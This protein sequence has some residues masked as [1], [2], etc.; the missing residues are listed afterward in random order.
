MSAK[1][2]RYLRGMHCLPFAWPGLE[3]PDLH[4]CCNIY[5]TMTVTSGTQGDAEIEDY[6]LGKQD[7]L[8][9]RIEWSVSFVRVSFHSVGIAWV[10]PLISSANCP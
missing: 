7:E 2:E 3:V 10:V 9:S 8:G 1:R 5:A 4:S 6:S